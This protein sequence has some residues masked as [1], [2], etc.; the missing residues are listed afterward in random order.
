MA[1]AVA[2]LNHGAN[3]ASLSL[4]F[5]ASKT[6]RMSSPFATEKVLIKDSIG[7]VG[8]ATDSR[9]LNLSRIAWGQLRRHRGRWTTDNLG[10]LHAECYGQDPEDRFPVLHASDLDDAVLGSEQLETDDPNQARDGDHLMC[11][12]QC[13]VCHFRNIQGRSPGGDHRD[14]LFMMCIRR[15]NS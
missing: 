8:G 6:I 5:E 1:S 15:A 7:P 12:F 14:K 10:M 3:R 13:D 11:P 9:S 2:K 4:L